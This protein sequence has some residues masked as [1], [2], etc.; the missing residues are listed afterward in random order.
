M[1]KLRFDVDFFIRSGGVSCI[2][3]WPID[4]NC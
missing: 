1:V 3:G 2:A 4:P